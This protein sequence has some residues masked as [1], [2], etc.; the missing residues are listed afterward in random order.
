MSTFRENAGALAALIRPDRVHARVYTDPEIFE[1]ERERL[2]ARSWQ[3]VGHASQ[4]PR[5]G[6]FLTADIAGQPLMMVR[7][8][9]GSVA[10]L[11][12]RCAHKG[13]AV[14][15]QKCG[16]AGK[17]LRCPYHAWTYRLDGSLI[18]MPLRAEYERTEL[19][20]CEAADG[21]VRVSSADY[22]GFIFARIASQGP[23]F[24]DYAGPMLQVLD[25]LVD[26]SPAGKLTIAGGCIR[27]TIRCNWKT[28]LENVNDAVHA[29][30]THESV[31]ATA[32]GLWNAQL[33]KRHVPMAMEQL[34][35][36]GSSLDIVRD[37]GA[38]VMAN[39]HSLLGTRASLHTGYASMASYE[40]ALAAVHGAERARQVLSFAPQN[41]IIFPS[42][43]LKCSPQVLR[44]VRPVSAD[45]TVVEAWS[46]RLEGAP[47]ELLR[48]TQHYNRLVYSPM[49]PVAH[50]DIHVFE[51]MQRAL[52]ARPN[53]WVS[54]HRLHST[55]ETADDNVEH[56][57]T[58]EIL[59]R[60]QFRAWL[61][62]M[63]EGGGAPAS[64]P[65]APDKTKTC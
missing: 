33:D 42:L 54:L 44:V 62:G 3:Y 65:A 45:C 57:A 13:T 50:D 40:A 60:N 29:I 37:M 18:S 49:S 14:L 61:H 23:S 48:R 31:I 11:L 28:Y 32:S 10:C 15:S 30:A 5:A 64:V 26:R 6:D 34:L 38:R 9:D 46:L 16:N 52:Q 63:S 4:V 43:A 36:F 41:A 51:S 59:M 47:D 55:D 20:H 53:P 17:V 1:L 39:G 25:N 24:E 21:L 22:R 56:S 19:A 7:Q 2:F 58:S 35:P 27:T 12:N 8:T